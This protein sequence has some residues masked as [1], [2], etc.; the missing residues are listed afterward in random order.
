MSNG[1]ETNTEKPKPKTLY[2]FR[3]W[4]IWEG[5]E[6]KPNCYHQSLL[7]EGI[8]WAPL[9]EKLNDLFDCGVPFRYDLMPRDDLISLFAATTQRER[10][11]LLWDQCLDQSACRIE[12]LGEIHRSAA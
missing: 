7:K 11:D 5:N 10:P 1:A 8:L 2:K 4:T 12:Q 9:A 6:E 3:T